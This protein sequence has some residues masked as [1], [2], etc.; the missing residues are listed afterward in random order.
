MGGVDELAPARELLANELVLIGRKPKRAHL[1]A[2]AGAFESS[3]GQDLEKLSARVVAFLIVPQAD[4][5][6]DRGA[7]RLLEIGPPNR[8][9]IGPSSRV[10]TAPWKKTKPLVSKP[11]R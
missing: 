7:A 5:L 2:D 8:S 1:D 11:V 4:V 10:S 3:L 6:D 9:V